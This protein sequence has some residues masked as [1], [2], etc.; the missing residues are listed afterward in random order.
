[1]NL[2]Y[3]LVL[4][5]LINILLILLCIILKIRKS[6]QRKQ[7]IIKET[8]QKKKEISSMLKRKG[9]EIE[10]KRKQLNEEE[11]NFHKKLHRIHIEIEGNKF[12]IIHIDLENTETILLPQNKHEKLNAN[13]LFKD[14]YIEYGLDDESDEYLISDIL[15]DIITKPLEIQKYV[16]WCG[17]IEYHVIG[18]TL[19]S[20]LFENFSSLLIQKGIKPYDIEITT[21][22]E[23]KIV[24]ERV[25]MA[26]IGM[27][28]QT[29]SLFEKMEMKYDREMIQ[30]QIMILREIYFRMHNN[31]LDN[32]LKEKYEKISENKINVIKRFI[33]NE[34]NDNK[35]EER[36][37]QF[38]MKTKI[39]LLKMNEKNVIVLPREYSLFNE[40]YV[41]SYLFE[42]EFR[43]EYFE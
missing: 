5:C 24:T 41:L 34:K 16:I 17:E 2:I 23:N 11:K 12:T 28:A 15:L 6:K 32:L 8:E 3:L 38:E 21:N 35:E 7:K 1:M 31:H 22:C 30:E 20:L 37:N 10:E 4:L 36:V 9:N 18:E 14:D 42:K 13:I 25:Q 40:G 27:I 39:N 29:Q 19:L 26:F 33:E 43:M